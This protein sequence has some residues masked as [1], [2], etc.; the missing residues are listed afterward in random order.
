MLS[1]RE[2]THVLTNMCAVV[3]VKCGICSADSL[4]NILLCCLGFVPGLLHSW[5]IIA[6]FPDPVEY[7]SVPQFADGENG[8]VRYVYVQAP[9]QQQQQHQ[10]Q[11]P[12]R[13]P[14]PQATPSNNVNYGTQGASSQQ[15]RLVD[16]GESSSG[17]QVPPSYAEVVGDHKVQSRD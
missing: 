10:Q 7:E 15:H 1:L 14:R 17:Q 6:K 3:W 5:Y 4:I 13:E 2:R 16:V 12:S 9:G 11:Q 8:R